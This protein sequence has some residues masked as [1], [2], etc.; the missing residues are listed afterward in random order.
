MPF[1]VAGNAFCALE[2]PD[3]LVCGRVSTR[4][5]RRRAGGGRGCRGCTSGAQL[6]V[7]RCSCPAFIPSCSPAPPHAFICLHFACSVIL[8][9]TTSLDS[10][11]SSRR[12]QA[13]ARDEKSASLLSYSHV[14]PDRCSAGG[15][16]WIF[17]HFLRRAGT[18]LSSARACARQQ[19]PARCAAM[20]PLMHWRSACAVWTK[21]LASQQA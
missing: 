19:D 5:V 7:P 16:R 4:R 8:G 1:L 6:H 10:Q 18:T 14:R 11:S 15:R 20:R 9:P 3:Q 12:S 2:L 17:A 13:A 21:R